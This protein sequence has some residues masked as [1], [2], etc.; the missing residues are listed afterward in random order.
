MYCYSKYIS[1]K[2]KADGIKGINEFC[3]HSVHMFRATSNKYC[4]QMRF[5]WK[6][7]GS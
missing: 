4:V 6:Q 5:A 2:Q 3:Y 7:N 1:I